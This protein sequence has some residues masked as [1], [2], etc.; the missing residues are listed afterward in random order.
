MS[1]THTRKKSLEIHGFLEA[2]VDN[3]TSDRVEIV[4]E[5]H[6]RRTTA[7]KDK[8]EESVCGEAEHKKSS[9]A[10]KIR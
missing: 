6:C 2:T 8:L 7:A 3:L 9:T 4:N 5:W 1:K 10:E